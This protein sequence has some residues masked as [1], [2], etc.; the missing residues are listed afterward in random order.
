MGSKKKG[1][2]G[3]HRSGFRAFPRSGTN[4]LVV[5]HPGS[6]CGSADFNYASAA[7]GEAR[8][9]ALEKEWRSWKGGIVVL[10]GILSDEL[11]KYSALNHALEEALLR[12]KNDDLLSL[13][14]H[15]GDGEPAR[16][17]QALLAGLYLPPEATRFIVTGAWLYP[18]CQ[19]CVGSVYR[20]LRQMGYRAALSRAVLTD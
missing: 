18:P 8:R 7:V 6:A 9:A 17:L 10:D 15:D 1:R 16:E 2:P 4:I 11:P 13:R 14:L 19:G 5:V 12:A 20:T 3:K